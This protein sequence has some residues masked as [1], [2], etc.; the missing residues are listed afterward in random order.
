MHWFSAKYPKR[1]YSIRFDYGLAFSCRHNTTTIDHCYQDN[2]QVPG[3]GA[4]EIE[5]ANQIAKFGEA[6]PG[7][8]QYAIKKFAQA[9]EVVPRAL[10]ENAGLKPTEIVSKLYASHQVQLHVV[11]W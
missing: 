8:E 2:K 10:A 7:L 5:L 3:A 9:L 1:L 4:T 11:F 6:C